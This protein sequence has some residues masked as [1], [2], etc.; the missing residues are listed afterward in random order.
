MMNFFPLIVDAIQ[1]KELE[2]CAFL[3]VNFVQKVS[4][5]E[6]FKESFVAYLGRYQVELAVLS[7]LIRFHENLCKYLDFGKL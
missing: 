7:D 2:N 1:T 5:F 3:S 4:K 6:Y